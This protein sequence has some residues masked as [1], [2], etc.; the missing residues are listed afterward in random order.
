MADSNEPKDTAVIT[1]EERAERFQRL[2][3]GEVSSAAPIEA[4]PVNLNSITGVEGARLL[5]E[6]ARRGR[7]AGIGLPNVPKPISDRAAKQER[8]DLN[9]FHGPR[10]SVHPY[11]TGYDASGESVSNLPHGGLTAT[12]HPTDDGQKQTPAT[13]ATRTAAD[14]ARISGGIP[15][16]GKAR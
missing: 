15:H 3:R 1:Q 13:E 8:D 2:A 12:P 5:E 4:P 14:M 6:A 10:S 16:G 7:E 9:R 11:P